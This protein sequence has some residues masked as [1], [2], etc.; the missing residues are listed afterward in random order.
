M[1]PSII[2]NFLLTRWTSQLNF[3]LPLQV[4]MRSPQCTI[5]CA[6]ISTKLLIHFLKIILHWNGRIWLHIWPNYSEKLSV[7]NILL[8]YGIAFFIPGDF[9][10]AYSR[11]WSFVVCLRLCSV[12]TVLIWNILLNFRIALLCTVISLMELI[13]ASFS[14]LLSVL[15]PWEQPIW[16]DLMADFAINMETET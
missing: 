10:D 8:E 14:L 16:Y 1:L 11:W 4:L 3:G 13:H 12:K 15:R 9:I 6:N 5:I 2:F 7:W